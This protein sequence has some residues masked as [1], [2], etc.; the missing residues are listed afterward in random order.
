ME[1]TYINKYNDGKFVYFDLLFEENC[2]ELLRM[3]G[4][5]FNQDYT[6][7]DMNDV[8]YFLAKNNLPDYQLIQ[9]IY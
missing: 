3:S 2:E 9:I 8:A 6:E 5:N 4:I 1:A 7:N